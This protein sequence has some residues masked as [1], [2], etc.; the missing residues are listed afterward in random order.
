MLKLV[1]TGRAGRT[2]KGGAGTHACLRCV[3]ELDVVYGLG[4]AP[5]APC[6]EEAVINVRK[7]QCTLVSVDA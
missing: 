5:K 4:A 3:F 2:V 7:A 6:T 1:A